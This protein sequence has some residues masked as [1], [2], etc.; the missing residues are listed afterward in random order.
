MWI[1]FEHSNI[2][3][4]SKPNLILNLNKGNRNRKKKL[5]QK[6]KGGQTYY[7]TT[8]PPRRPNSRTTLC[9]LTRRHGASLVGQ[10][11][12]RDWVVAA[13]AKRAPPVCPPD[14]V[15]TRSQ[16]H[17]HMGPRV[18]LTLGL[19]KG[20]CVTGMWTTTLLPPRVRCDRG[21]KFA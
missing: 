11:S 1:L 15:R 14:Y 12:H 5:K 8:L 19:P 4:I 10:T 13:V 21:D 16:S 2:V 3:C 6:R 18:S 9:S 17:C 20:F 7:R